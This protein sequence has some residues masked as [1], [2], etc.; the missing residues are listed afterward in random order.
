MESVLLTARV[1]Q[2]EDRYVASVE[3]L[4]LEAIGNSVRHAQ[5]EL[6]TALRSWIETQDTLGHLEESLAE[7]GY[8][9]VGEDTKLHLEFVE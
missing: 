5:D 3:A 6:V 9:G 4:A 7:A 8:A 1:V 2:E